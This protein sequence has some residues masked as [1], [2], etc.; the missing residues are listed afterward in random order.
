MIFSDGH[1]SHVG[2][3]QQTQQWGRSTRPLNPKEE[4][5]SV[6]VKQPCNAPHPIGIRLMLSCSARAVE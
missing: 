5:R 2:Y 6:G 3:D 4:E 1:R